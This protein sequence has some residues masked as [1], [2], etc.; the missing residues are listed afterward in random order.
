M[1][2]EKDSYNFTY[3]KKLLCIN[4]SYEYIEQIQTLNNYFHVQGAE[5][6]SIISII[7]QYHLRWTRIFSNTQ[8]WIQCGAM[9]VFCLFPQQNPLEDVFSVSVKY[10]LQQNKN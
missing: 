2:E 4:W 6:S 7:I 10:K 5:H 3:T 9:H 8:N 1:N